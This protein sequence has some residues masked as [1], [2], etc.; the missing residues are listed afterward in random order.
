MSPKCVHDKKKLIF[1]GNS[2]LYQNSL[3]WTNI[4]MKIGGSSMLWSLACKWKTSFLPTKNITNP[5][6]IIR[7]RTCNYQCSKMKYRGNES[8]Q[9]QFVYNILA[10]DTGFAKYIH[11]VTTLYTIKK[12]MNGVISCRLMNRLYSVS[13]N[14]R[15]ITSYR[16]Q[17]KVY[18][19]ACKVPI[20][21]N[22]RST[23]R[24]N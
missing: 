16:Y 23:Q 22:M 15:A 24:Y 20:L 10:T 4:N 3:I 6:L 19:S 2:H 8:E 17:Q 9:W 14:L 1:G 13:T 12:R 5:T 11:V 18:N 21:Y 7:S